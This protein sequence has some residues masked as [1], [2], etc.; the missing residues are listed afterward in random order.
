MSKN[1]KAVKY[2]GEFQRIFNETAKGA[3]LTREQVVRLNQ[4]FNQA[5]VSARNAGKLGKTF[6]QTMKD[7][8]SSFSYWTSSTFI[9]MKTFSEILQAVTTVNE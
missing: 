3:Q 7:G 1:G 5:V 6:F 4:E 8:M 9:V 2:S